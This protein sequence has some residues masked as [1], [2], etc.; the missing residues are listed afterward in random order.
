M[1]ADPKIVRRAHAKF[2]GVVGVFLRILPGPGGRVA[3]A[4]GF[5][6]GALLE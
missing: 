5:G 6:P 1:P 2:V 4:G 3:D